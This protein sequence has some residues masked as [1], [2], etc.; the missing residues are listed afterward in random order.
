MQ[1]IS[2]DTKV[3]NNGIDGNI[4]QKCIRGKKSKKKQKTTTTTTTAT[5][6]VYISSG[7]SYLEKK[8]NIYQTCEI[9]F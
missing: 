8:S 2:F 9:S 4:C 1:R 5:T 3:E 7:V 6:N